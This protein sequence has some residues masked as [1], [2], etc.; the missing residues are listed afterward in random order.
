M[1]IPEC[2]THHPILTRNPVEYNKVYSLKGYDARILNGSDSNFA[3]LA[4]SQH[5]F[6]ISNALTS[7]PQPRQRA[8]HPQNLCF[9]FVSKTARSVCNADIIK[10]V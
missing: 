3:A 5:G 8:L 7:V 6:A 10:R 4:N 2:T 9:Y 1:D